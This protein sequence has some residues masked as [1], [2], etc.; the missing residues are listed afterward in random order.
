MLFVVPSYGVLR[1]ALNKHNKKRGCG[2]VSCISWLIIVVVGGA[3]CLSAF[4]ANQVKINSLPKKQERVLSFEEIG[5]G[6]EFF[7]ISD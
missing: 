5:L 7:P 4:V 1:V 6:K 3:L 2:W